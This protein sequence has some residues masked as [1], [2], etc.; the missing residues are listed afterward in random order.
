MKSK[1]PLRI[2]IIVG[3]IGGIIFIAFLCLYSAYFFLGGPI[4]L[5]RFDHQL[6]RVPFD[7][8]LW[9]AEAEIPEHEREPTREYMIDD[10]LDRYDFEGWSIDDVKALLGEPDDTRNDTRMIYYKLGRFNHYFYL[11]F[12]EKGLVAEYTVVWDV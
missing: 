2:F 11:K 1:T 7:K 6:N 12:D 3:T 4:L 10:L 8:D 9:K 5:A